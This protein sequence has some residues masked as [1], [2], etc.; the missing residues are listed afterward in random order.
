MLM[1][2]ASEN[3]PVLLATGVRLPLDEVAATLLLLGRL[4]AD[5]DGDRELVLR[6]REACL[7][8]HPI[9]EGV[10]ARLAAEGFL[11]ED[12]AVVPFVREVV[13]AAVRGEGRDLHLVSP[14]VRPW[15]RTRSDLIVARETVRAALPPHEAAQLL[16]G[17]PGAGDPAS[18]SWI[19]R[20]FRRRFRDGNPPPPSLN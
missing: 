8:D 14:F 6:L 11:S 12:G 5:P 1:N 3:Q 2:H 4:L 20:T 7:T 15:D 18:G 19:E 13:K 16:G 17:T 10:R 9:P